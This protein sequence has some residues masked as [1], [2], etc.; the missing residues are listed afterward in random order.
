MGWGGGG[1][2]TM[3]KTAMVTKICSNNT[4]SKTGK[5]FLKI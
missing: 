4:D 2:E 5:M 1:G 3:I